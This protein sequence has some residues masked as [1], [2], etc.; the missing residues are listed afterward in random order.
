MTLSRRQFAAALALSAPTL[1]IAQSESFDWPQWRGPRRNGI[2]AEKDY[3]AQWPKEGPRRLWATKVG[4]GYS[5]VSVA[6]GKL[7]TMGNLSD[8]DH[9]QCLDTAN[10]K[11]VWDYKYPCNAAD[12]N[13]YPGPRCTPTVDG[14]LVF[15]VSRNGHLLC[16]SAANGALVWTKNLVTDF[17]GYI[18]QWGYSGSPLVEGELLILETGS[19]GRSVAALEKKTGRVVWAN[20]NAAA[21]YASPMAFDVARERAVAVFSAAGLTGRA[22]SNGRVLWHYNWRTSYDVNAATPIIFDDKIFISSGYGT[23][24]ALLQ[25]SATAA[26]LVWQNKGMRN[27]MNSCVLWQGHLYGFDEAQLR[28][29]D[30]ITG[31]VKWSTPA[32]GKGS[33]MLADS[34][35]IL[36][37]ERGRLGLAEASPA[38]FREL[39]AAQVLGGS[40]TWAPP[41]LS[42]GR[43]YCRSSTDLVCLDVSGK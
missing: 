43:I 33:L 23:G 14:N 35:L 36:Y 31:V 24:C 16:L 10:G 4:V 38:G 42:N 15:T 29:L 34:R 22:L 37:G 3:I 40:S 28:C 27:H 18:P 20:G 12:P 30:V 2:S 39:A 6:G 19:S 1:A 41:V 8:V 13:G 9:V 26:K 32:Y 17:G 7:Y 21:G 5:S 25:I 11:L